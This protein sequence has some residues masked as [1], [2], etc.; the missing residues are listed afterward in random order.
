M[1]EHRDQS[2]IAGRIRGI[3]ALPVV[4]WICAVSGGTNGGCANGSGAHATGHIGSAAIGGAAA[5]DG[6]AAVGAATVSATRMNSTYPN[7][8]TTSAG[9]HATGAGTAGTGTASCVGLSGHAC[10]DK[11][12]SRKAG[13]EDSER[14]AS[15]FLC[16]PNPR[17]IVP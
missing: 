10:D 11:D 4:V 13:N 12:S 2:S 14:H 15:P 1:P 9:M 5:I 3:S 8:A 17:V 16:N 7:S 6:S